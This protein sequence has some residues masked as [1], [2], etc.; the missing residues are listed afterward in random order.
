MMSPNELDRT[1]SIL[2]EFTYDT[3]DH[4]RAASDALV[5]LGMLGEAS[6]V[7]A[8]SQA[9]LDILRRVSGRDFLLTGQVDGR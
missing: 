1:Q 2:R 5:A 7:T 4:C 9:L 8:A 6:E 3:C